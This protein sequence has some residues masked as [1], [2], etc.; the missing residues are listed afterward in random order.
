MGARDVSA[1]RS[2]VG[3]WEV[4]SDHHLTKAFKFPDFRSAL[5][6]VNRVGEIAEAEGHHPDI[7][8]SWGRVRITLWTHSAGGLTDNDFIM[9]AKIDKL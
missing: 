7:E 2:R 9:A 8:L 4:V 3:S 1:L 6:F 5:I